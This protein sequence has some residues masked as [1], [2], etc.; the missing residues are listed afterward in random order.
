MPRRVVQKHFRVTFRSGE[1]AD[2]QRDRA[3]PMNPIGKVPTV[4]FDDGRVLSKSV[5]ILFYLAYGT[6][7]STGAAS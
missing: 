5:P 6:Q 3:C 7:R 4:R 1:I 2:Q